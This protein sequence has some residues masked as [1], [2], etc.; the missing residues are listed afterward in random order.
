MAAWR[1]SKADPKLPPSR[2]PPDVQNTTFDL[3]FERLYAVVKRQIQKLI[4]AQ[5]EPPQPS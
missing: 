4:Q 5:S 3:S 2:R 1:D